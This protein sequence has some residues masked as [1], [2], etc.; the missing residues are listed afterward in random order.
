ME[1]STVPSYAP[2]PPQQSCGIGLVSAV[3]LS[4]AHGD[5]SV[6]PPGS[7]V[8]VEVPFS[9]SWTIV[10]P[11]PAACVATLTISAL[12]AYSLH[13]TS[14]RVAVFDAA[15]G[16][17]LYDQTGA[18]RAL[19]GVLA[20]STGQGLVVVYNWTS[21]GGV[22]SPSFVDGMRASWDAV[23]GSPRPFATLVMNNTVFANNSAAGPG[24]A[25]AMFLDAGFAGSR[26]ASVEQ[27]ELREPQHMLLMPSD[28]QPQQ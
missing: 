7:H 27:A 21:Y 10:P 12:P 6:V 15:T 26:V 19:P 18:P 13:P 2:I 14:S 3:Q 20:S 1:W 28:A 23:C 16:S 17:A 11:D 24:G 25:L 5:L 22:S 4:S 8:P 9:C